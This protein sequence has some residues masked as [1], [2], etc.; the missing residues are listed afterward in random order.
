MV[1]FPILWSERGVRMA[2][3]NDDEKNETHIRCIGGVYL[4]LTPKIDASLFIP[5]GKYLSNTPCGLES[6]RK[7]LEIFLNEKFDEKEAK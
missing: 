1:S 5:L 6:T 2:L 3:R 7:N 4:I